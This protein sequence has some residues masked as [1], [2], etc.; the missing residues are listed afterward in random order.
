MG[1]IIVRLAIILAILTVIA[2]FAKGCGHTVTLKFPDTE[3]NNG[4]S[5]SS[6]VDTSEA[7]RPPG[8]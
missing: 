1:I 4:R 2:I 3:I 8:S 5:S 7:T 6:T